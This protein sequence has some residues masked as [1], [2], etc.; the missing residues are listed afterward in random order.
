LIRT[1]VIAGLAISLGGCF[2]G[3]AGWAPILVSKEDKFSEGTARSILK[4]NEYGVALRC[5]AFKPKGK[6]F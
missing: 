1:C 3:C 4:H 5:P 6:W 2:G